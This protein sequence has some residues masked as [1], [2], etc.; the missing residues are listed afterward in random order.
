MGSLYLDSSAVVKYYIAETGSTW[1]QQIVD[2]RENT[3]TVSQLT[4][5]EVAAA[6][7]RR[8]RAKEI[9]QR[10][11]VRTLARLGIDFRQRYSIAQVSDPIVELAVE[12]TGRHPLRA[13]DA[14]QLATALLLDRIL[15]GHRLPPLTF[16]CADKALCS[17][18]RAEGMD[19]ENPNGYP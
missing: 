10:H 11:R 1:V 3:V 8:R 4:A 13:Y 12:L 19:A 9:S 16:V 15:R 5:V 17:A 2:D 6:V 18:A 7:E 14:L